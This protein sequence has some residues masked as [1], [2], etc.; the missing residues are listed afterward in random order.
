VALLRA[1]TDVDVPG[2]ESERSRDRLLLILERRARQIEVHPVLARL[3]LLGRKKSDPEPGVIV[4]HERNAVVG[5]FG[6]L[7]AQDTSPEARESGRVERVEA[8]SVEVRGHPASHLRS[9]DSQP[10][11]EEQRYDVV[12]IL[13][14]QF[15]QLMPATSVASG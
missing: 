6:H 4:R 3:L 14:G 11:Q 8:E 9:A 10:Y 15:G 5:V 12:L 7:P 2:A 13:G 1:L